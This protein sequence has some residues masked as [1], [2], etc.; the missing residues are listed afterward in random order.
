MVWEEKY[1][2]KYINMASNIGKK[3][4][5]L[6]E[7][8]KV[9]V[10]NGKVMVSGPKGSLAMQ[11]PPGIDIVIEKDMITIKKQ[12]ES[13]ELEKYY[14]LARA[15][16]FNLVTGVEV[17]FDKKLE[18]SGVGY[19][20]RVEGRDLVLNVGFA[21]PIKIVAPESITFKVEENIISV[22]GI[23]KELIGGIASKIRKVRPPDPYKGKG[24]AYFGEKLRKKVGKA[25]QKAGVK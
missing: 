11:L 16:V 8:I 18:L 15:L 1:W 4:I 2:R 13:Q 9:S 12:N 6:K 25:A 19:R 21:N 5:P 7:G 3:V 17:G 14:G 22:S 10:E 24:I 23:D 20:A